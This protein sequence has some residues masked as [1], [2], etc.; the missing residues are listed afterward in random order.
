MLADIICGVIDSAEERK[1]STNVVKHSKIPRTEK[2]LEQLITTNKNPVPKNI[3][4][5]KNIKYGTMRK[6]SIKDALKLY[7]LMD[8]DTVK[9]TP[10]SIISELETIKTKNLVKRSNLRYFSMD[11][12]VYS[13]NKTDINAS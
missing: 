2:D 12:S 4:F 3:P 10:K 13:T 11:M 1:E 5:T 6:V 7:L 9:F 8:L